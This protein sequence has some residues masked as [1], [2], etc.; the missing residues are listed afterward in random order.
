M[1]A[2]WRTVQDG[3]WVVLSIVTG[4]SVEPGGRILVADAQPLVREGLKALF[5][6]MDGVS[7]VAEVSSG[8]GVLTVCDRARPDLLLLDCC[9]PEKD[10]VLIARLI[11]ARGGG[12]RVLIL[13][14]HGGD[15]LDPAV[16]AG[17]DGLL[18]KEADHEEVRFAVRSVLAGGFFVSPSVAGRL[19]TRCRQGWAL[20]DRRTGGWEAL[21][22]REREVLH[23]VAEGF[24]NREIADLLVVSEKTVEKHRANFMAKL[25]LHSAAEVRAFAQRQGLPLRLRDHL[26]EK[27]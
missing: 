20:E 17:A 14:G 9:L 22:P 6:V 19:A 4:E 10:G 11:R 13:C 25:G 12:E 18:L 1:S 8:G 27:G 24:R 3:A 2:R 5:G 15:C 21:T 26:V 7:V 23:Y 16:A